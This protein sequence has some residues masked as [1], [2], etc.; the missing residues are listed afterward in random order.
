MRTRNRNHPFALAVLPLA[1]AAALP[2]Y[3][4]DAEDIAELAQKANSVSV[5]VQ[6]ASGDSNDRAIY[7]QFNGRRKH[8]YN[9]LLDIYFSKRDENSGIR[10]Y[11]E[12]RDL[13]TEAR[14]F[15]A[16]VERQGDFKAY[17]DYWQI[18]R[19]EPRT[20][21]TF[22]NGFATMTPTVNLGS[23]VGAG[24]NV[25]LKQERKRT[26]VGGEKWL[27]QNF[28]LEASFINEQKEGARLFGRG[29]N[30]PSGAAPVG[31]CTALAT[32]ANQWATLLLAEPRDSVA[33][34]MEL[35]GTFFGDRWSVTAGYYGSFYNNDS[36]NISPT[37]SGNLNNP[38]GLPMGTPT[39]VAL[40]AGLRNILQQP[41]A[42]WP[43]NQAHQ[44]SANGYWAITPGAKLT[45]KAAYTRQTQ[46]E[47]FRSS[48]YTD[49]P[50]GSSSLDGKVNI[51]LA[52][53]GLNLKPMSKLTV[54]ASARY[55]D[56]EDKTPLNLYNIEGVNRFVNG[57]YSLKRAGLK[58]DATYQFPF[59]IRGT[60]GVERDSQDRG[61]YLSPE[62]VDLGD[63]R[64]IGDSIG[65][66]S[67][68]RAKTDE[69]T[70]RAEVRR[71]LG[72]ML[73]GSIGLFHSSRDGSNWLKP[74]AL[75]ATGFNEVSDDVAYAR[76]GIFPSMFMNRKR[77]KVRGVINFAPAEKVQL[78]F[79]AEDGRDKYS[80]PTEKGLSKTGMGTYAVDA[81]YVI[82]DAW[83][84]SGYYS[85]AESTVNVA[86]STGY[87]MKIKDR[88]AT[89][90]VNVKGKVTPKFSFGADLLVIRGR[91]IYDQSLDALASA[92]NNTFLAASGGLP[93]VMFRDTRLK[94]NGTYALAKNQDLKLEVVHD[95][96]K[97]DE[98]TWSYNGVPYVF[99]DNTT[100]FMQPSQKAT[101]V[102]LLYTYRWR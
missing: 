86:H 39:G 68:L 85:F 45:F 87:V 23:R 102:S 11:L 24:E 73:T 8:D 6:G 88:N 74:V 65:G 10:Y 15:K 22:Q 61:N 32:G 60:V 41:M 97:L 18:S 69:T 99:S 40:T 43:D 70:W 42:L 9:L 16:G 75:P 7:G 55:E 72:D 50:A 91:N 57:T 34:Q 62:C 54:N 4:G 44:F 84:V 51:T 58:A 52:Q 64:C 20:V 12:G 53:V 98:W 5:G 82:N 30:C 3:A 31:V 17:V 89:F 27:G 35:K 28:V 78:Q 1:L 63:G 2:A 25:E 47:D 95:R 29:F 21:N 100:V 76:T 48:G 49:A 81:S 13:G 71:N 33:R 36:G 96:T 79:V 66:I 59:A 101:Y 92:A 46:N 26:T 19:R 80:G 56:R 90:G 37:I 77:D 67:A 14:E 83:R 93:D 38:L 94:L